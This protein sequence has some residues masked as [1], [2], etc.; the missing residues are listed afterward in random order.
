[1][2][3]TLGPGPPT[4]EA[5]PS[6]HGRDGRAG[7]V[8]GTGPSRREATPPPKSELPYS[9]AAMSPSRIPMTIPLLADTLTLTEIGPGDK[10]QFDG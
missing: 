4:Q 7:Q 10:V 8:T 6:Q 5:R 9:R 2:A 1:M 3:R